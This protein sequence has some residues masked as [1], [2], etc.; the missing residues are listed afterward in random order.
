MALVGAPRAAAAEVPPAAA[1]VLVDAGSGAVLDGANARTPLPP[2]SL[3]KVVTALAV[4]RS[5]PPAATVPVSPRAAAMPPTRLGM[6]AGQVWQVGD[7]LAALLLS[8]S[9]D[10]AM[11]LAESV[12][13]TAERFSATMQDTAAQLGM[14]DRPVLRDPA[15]LDGAAGLGGGN[16]LSAADLAIAAR[17]ALDDPRVA[18]VMGLRD[19]RL[20][21]P[22]G[23]PR[24]LVNHNRLLWSYPGAVGVKTG[25]TRAAGHCLIAAARR[26]GRTVIAVVMH[27]SDVYSTARALLD[28]GFA[29]APPPSAERL[30]APRPLTATA[31]A[32]QPVVAP[33]TATTPGV[34]GLPLVAGVLVLVVCAAL[35]AVVVYRIRPWEVP[36]AARV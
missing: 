18:S 2:A 11:A 12:S 25:Y 35:G 15:G 14:R 3:T 36:A 9:N 32:P 19:H 28:R 5:L 16:L 7:A 13:G 34:G 33:S 10:A 6:R 8:S 29:M 23:S 21:G 22:D 4:A 17:A 24:R 1:W 30:P 31:L 20:T 27:G 26:D